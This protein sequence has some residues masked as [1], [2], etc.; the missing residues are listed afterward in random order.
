VTGYNNYGSGATMAV[1]LGDFNGDGL[2][3]IAVAARSYSGPQ[4]IYSYYYD[5][6]GNQIWTQDGWATPNHIFVIFGTDEEMGS[7]LRVRNM[8]SAD[9]LSIGGLTGRLVSLEA[10]GDVNGD[11]AADLMSAIIPSRRMIASRATAPFW[12]MSSSAA[13]MPR[14]IPCPKASTSAIWMATPALPCAARRWSSG[15]RAVSMVRAATTA[16]A[17]IMAAAALTRSIQR[18]C[19]LATSTAMA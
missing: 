2:A 11:G 3:D 16:R 5:Y 15:T 14:S 6:Y 7:V 4:S 10:A 18:S 9:H 13:A 12:A 1:G 19:R 17:G 8:D